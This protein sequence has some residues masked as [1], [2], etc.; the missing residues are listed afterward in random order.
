MCNGPR[1][2][3]RPTP[4]RAA[5]DRG[6]PARTASSGRVES[7]TF[8]VRRTGDIQGKTVDMQGSCGLLLGE[9]P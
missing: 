6:V 3:A 8:K 2:V 7:G 5:G 1:S 4:V 9:E